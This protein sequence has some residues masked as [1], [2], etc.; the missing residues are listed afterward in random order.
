[1]G[2]FLQDVSVED[3]V[4]ELIQN[5]LDA[6]STVTTISFHNDRLICEGNGRQIDETG[7]Q[8]LAM[9]MGAGG[10]VAAKPDGIGAK[11]RGLRTAFLVGDTIE[12]QSA[13]T[14]IELT[15]TC[16][17]RKR[18]FDPGTL[19]RISDPDAPPKGTRITVPYR[20]SPLRVPSAE[21]SILPRFGR[22][23]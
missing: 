4:I 2:E 13:G 6:G 9:I 21:G 1:M 18:V 12:V 5:E 17:A 15:V 22:N 7:W 19:P 8:R 16:T 11:N 14:G 3:V 10:Q 20:K 23:E